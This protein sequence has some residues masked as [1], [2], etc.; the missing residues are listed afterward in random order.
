MDGAYQLDA[1]LPQVLTPGSYLAT[2]EIK[3]TDDGSG[4]PVDTFTSVVGSCRASFATS[5]SGQSLGLEVVRAGFV[6]L[7]AFVPDM[8]AASPGPVGSAPDLLDLHPFPATLN[9]L[10]TPVEGAVM[11]AASS[12]QGL[13]IAQPFPFALGHCGLGSPVDVDGSLWDPLAGV[14]ALGGSLDA[15]EEIGELINA[16]AGQAT[17]VDADRLDLRTPAGSV[18]VF[19]RHRGWRFYPWCA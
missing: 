8:P 16:T 6:C 7:M 5:P 1:G 10:I 4:T 11:L 9:Q 13:E 12:R 14:D 17:L 19:A 2:L 15:Q 18:I 3:R